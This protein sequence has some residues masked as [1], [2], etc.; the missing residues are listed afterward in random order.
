[1]RSRIEDA[2]V[3]K[4]DGIIST[5]QYVNLS[6]R[7]RTDL[8]Q[9]ERAIAE[10][11]QSREKTVGRG[12]KAFELSQDQDLARTFVTKKPPVRRRIPNA[13]CLNISLDD[14]TLVPTYNG[15]FDLLAEG[16]R[17]GFESGRL[18]SNQR[19]LRPERS[20][21]A[22]LSHA[23]LLLAS[24]ALGELLSSS[25]QPCPRRRQK[26]DATAMGWGCQRERIWCREHLQKPRAHAW[27]H[28]SDNNVCLR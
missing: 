26:R 28:T 11:G 4:L 7:W 5:E 21:L 2:Y 23:P 13:L 17:N 12:L 6:C 9:I 8:D 16:R 14:V 27:T 3:D 24:S 10:H 20:A 18:D 1:M 19:P 15:P 25:A 22:R